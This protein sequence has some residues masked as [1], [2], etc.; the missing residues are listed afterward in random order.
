MENGPSPLGPKSPSLVGPFG[1]HWAWTGSETTRTQVPPTSTTSFA[2][3]P[4]YV[5]PGTTFGAVAAPDGPAIADATPNASAIDPITTN[6]RRMPPS[7]E[8]G[9]VLHT[10]RA[11]LTTESAIWVL[12]T[13]P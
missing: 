9:G 11:P 5:A 2:P 6:H 13:L 10:T 4:E 8:T 1:L 12:L 7:V 3:D